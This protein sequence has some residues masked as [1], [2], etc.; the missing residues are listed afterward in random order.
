MSIADIE[1]LEQAGAL[2]QERE[3][4]EILKEPKKKLI[5]IVKEPDQENILKRWRI[6]IKDLQLA[7]RRAQFRQIMKQLM[8]W[9]QIMI[10]RR[11]GTHQM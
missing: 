11:S 6:R 8:A 3:D 10:D 4:Q 9:G 5:T 7:A 1:W 2:D